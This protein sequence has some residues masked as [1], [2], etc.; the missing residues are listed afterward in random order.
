[1]AWLAADNFDQQRI[2]AAAVDVAEFLSLP[3]RLVNET[4]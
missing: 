1:M 4:G 2:A 3:N